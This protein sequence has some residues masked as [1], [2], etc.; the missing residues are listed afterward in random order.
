MS[1]KANNIKRMK[2]AKRMRRKL[3]AQMMGPSDD[4]KIPELV[5]LAETPTLVKLSA[6][7][8]QAVNAMR[9]GR[10][11]RKTFRL[12][13]VAV[14]DG[15]AVIMPE[16]F[17]FDLTGVQSPADNY[18][19]ACEV[20][21]R[22]A[23]LLESEDIVEKALRLVRNCEATNAKSWKPLVVTLSDYGSD[24]DLKLLKP[25]E[26][27]TLLYHRM[28]NAVISSLLR[29]KNIRVSSRVISVQDYG[30][31]L[32]REKLANSAESRSAYLV[33]SQYGNSNGGTK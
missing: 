17:G 30:A 24:D 26:N 18:D 7:P 13:A 22:T 20:V 25:E 11:E 31:W 33:S 19:S 3:K 10:L 9:V 16:F 2:L 5:E 1:R 23:K 14:P 32:K 21:K 15:T 8:A 29:E 28:Q 6:G 4:V 27:Y 12:F